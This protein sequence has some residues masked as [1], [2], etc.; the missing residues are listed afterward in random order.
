M[1]PV[2]LNNT[3]P[4]HIRYTI[5]HP[6][7][8]KV[9]T[10]DIGTREL[11]L[12]EEQLQQ[13]LQVTKNAANGKT[14]QYNEEDWDGEDEEEE[15]TETSDGQ[16]LLGSAASQKL[17]KTQSIVHLKV[18]KPGTVR[19]IRV[20]DSTTSNTARIYPNEI[21]VVPCPRVSFVPD[22]IAS[23][24][25]I[26]CVGSKEELGVKVYGVPPLTLKWH[27]EINGRREHFSVD[28]IEGSPEVSTYIP[29]MTKLS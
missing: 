1:I 29:S 15:I 22:K 16:R 21:P 10:I 3:K 2:L 9:D 27:R 8:Q 4:S 20:L 25:D 11:R 18:T 19:L 28:R 6:N 24:N 23:G 5:S 13:A 14:D 26:R 17:E 12:I 7:S